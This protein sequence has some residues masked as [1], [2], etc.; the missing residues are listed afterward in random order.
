[1]WG[2]VTGNTSVAGS[3]PTLPR[4]ALSHRIALG[5]ALQDPAGRPPPPISPSALQPRPFPLPSRRGAWVLPAPPGSPPAASESW[6]GGD[7]SRGRV[8][9]ATCRRLAREL[10]SSRLGCGSGR[11]ALGSRGGKGFG[12]SEWVES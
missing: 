1:M 3:V 8:T 10:A 4:G 5:W 6:R 12:R 7:V 9:F 11:Q 2:G